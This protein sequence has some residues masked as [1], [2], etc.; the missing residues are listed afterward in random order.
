MGLDSQNHADTKYT[1]PGN[2]QRSGAS[3]MSACGHPCPHPSI[4][5]RILRATLVRSAFGSGSKEDPMNI[6]LARRAAAQPA[7]PIRRLAPFAAEA[8]ELGRHVFQLNI[9]QPDIAAPR[10]VLARLRSR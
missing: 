5:N 9:G 8:R 2:S 6:R 7:S 10:E 4:E 1:I 3:G